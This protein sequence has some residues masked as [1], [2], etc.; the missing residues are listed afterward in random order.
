LHYAGSRGAPEPLI[1]RLLASGGDRGA[2]TAEG[3]TP[4]AVAR[5]AGKTKAAAALA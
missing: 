3:L 1:A 2:R 4:A 5:A